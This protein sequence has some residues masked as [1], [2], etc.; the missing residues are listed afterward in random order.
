MTNAVV[1]DDSRLKKRGS[2]ELGNDGWR[3]I[4]DVGD[5]GGRQGMKERKWRGS[6]CW[7][8]GQ[9]SSEDSLHCNH[10]HPLDLRFGVCVWVFVSV[11][12]TKITDY[13]VLKKN[14]GYK[15]KDLILCTPEVLGL[16]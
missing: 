15:K 5:G 10:I 16:F 8:V 4:V 7:R 13:L 6:D 9:A 1:K 12:V 2:D 14:N 11:S 3:R